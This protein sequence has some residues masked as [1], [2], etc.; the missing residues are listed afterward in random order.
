MPGPGERN[1]VGLCAKR[2]RTWVI[3]VATGLIVASLALAQEAV[4]WSYRG[5]TGPQHWGKLSPA[6]AACATGSEQ[7]PVDI[8]AHAPA[9]PPIMVNYHPGALTIFNNGHTVQVN[10]DRG[11]S[12]MLDG[13][14]YELL[15]FHVH[16][17]SEHTG[18][19]Q[20]WPLEK[21]IVHR[22]AQGG[23]AVIGVLAQAGRPH[24]A[25]APVI[26]NLPAKEGQPAPVAGVRVDANALLPAQR[27]YW[28]YEGSLTT[29]PCTEQVKWL[30]LTRP[31]ELSAAQ[32]AAFTRIVS[33]NARPVQALHGRQF[34][35][36]P[37]LPAAGA[38]IELV[39]LLA[40]AGL[41]A[42]AGGLTLRVWSRRKA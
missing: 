13:M 26:A 42:F 37:A 17:P 18:K 14:P 31:V 8:P 29:P 27:T 38:A 1:S 36:A 22:K 23:L 12:I 30:V 10:Y 33:H 3:A 21:H 16:T 34:L 6:F 4:H 2:R 40:G 39:G 20:R 11:S 25:Y 41:L 9:N 15:Q 35:L 32:I 19:G 24:R 5:A 28:R 7:S